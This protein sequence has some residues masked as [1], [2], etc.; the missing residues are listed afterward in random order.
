MQCYLHYY[1]SS[2]GTEIII[3][4]LQAY[5]LGSGQYY[6]ISDKYEDVSSLLYEDM[7]T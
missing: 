6:M 5:M 2:G 3:T 4:L 1:R 7:R